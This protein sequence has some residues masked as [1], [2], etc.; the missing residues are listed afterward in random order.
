MTSLATTTSTPKHSAITKSQANILTLLYGYRF[1][2][3]NQIQAF[4]GHANKS[5]INKWLRDLYNKGYLSRSFKNTLGENTK[6]AVYCCSLGAIRHFKTTDYAS[7]QV[8][9][10]LYQDPRRTTSFITSSLVLADIALQLENATNKTLRFEFA[11]SNIYSHP[12]SRAHFLVDERLY[13]AAVI[14]KAEGAVYTPYLIEMVPY[15]LPPSRLYGIIN[16]YLD[17]YFASGW[18]NHMGLTFPKIFFACATTRQLQDAYNFANMQL[19]DAEDTEDLRLI[20][21][22]QS[23]LQTNFA[24]SIIDEEKT[25]R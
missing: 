4:L 16:A 6:P 21:M 13:P 1:L 10:R 17:L 3:R 12:E 23:A 2:S 24:N 5:K 22:T 19:Q 9:K 25:A 20:F 8:I 15:G 18:E 11:T 14:I 7:E